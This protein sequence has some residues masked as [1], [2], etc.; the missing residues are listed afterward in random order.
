MTQDIETEL[1]N[2]I[3]EY[4]PSQDGEDIC[5]LYIAKKLIAF[6]ESQG[7]VRTKPAQRPD[8]PYNSDYAEPFNHAI[9]AY[10]KANPLGL[11]TRKE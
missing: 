5:N 10:E 2:K 8:N 11:L 9:V 7:F 6:L 4:I 1:A 3:A